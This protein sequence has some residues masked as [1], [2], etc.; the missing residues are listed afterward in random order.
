M[1]EKNLDKEKPEY[2]LALS[3]I[4]HY[5]FISTQQSDRKLFL[6]NFANKA[7]LSNLWKYMQQVMKLGESAFVVITDQVF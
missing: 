6:D 7:K 1:I 2:I 3:M 5:S 4:K